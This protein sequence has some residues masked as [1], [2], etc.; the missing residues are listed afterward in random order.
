MLYRH[1]RGMYDSYS[2]AEVQVVFGMTWVRLLGGLFASTSLLHLTQCSGIREAE[3]SLG[4]RN[5]EGT[6]SVDFRTMFESAPLPSPNRSVATRMIVHQ[7]SQF[8]AQ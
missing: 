6:K 1:I 4:R 5:T 3:S 8:R 7:G 2:Q